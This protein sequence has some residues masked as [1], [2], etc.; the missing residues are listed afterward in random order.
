MESKE[1][2]RKTGRGKITREEKKKGA[3]PFRGISVIK[4]ETGVEGAGKKEIKAFGIFLVK[5]RGERKGKT[6]PGSRWCT[7]SFAIT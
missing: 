5:V 3:F 7:F 1:K 2:K 4:K 6:N